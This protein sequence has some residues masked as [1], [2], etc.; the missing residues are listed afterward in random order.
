MILI[1]NEIKE[2]DRKLSTLEILEIATHIARKA[3]RILPKNSFACDDVA[4]DILKMINHEFGCD[5]ANI[6]KKH[7]AA[8]HE[9]IDCYE[10]PTVLKEKWQL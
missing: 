2:S 4:N 3:N 10:I 5:L 1:I 8:I 7:I 6:K 9:F